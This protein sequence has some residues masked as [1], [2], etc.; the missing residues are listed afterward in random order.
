MGC[1]ALGEI[2]NLSEF[3]PPHHVGNGYDTTALPASPRGEE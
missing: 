3:L 2:F 1:V